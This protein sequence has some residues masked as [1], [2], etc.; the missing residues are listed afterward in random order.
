VSCTGGTAC[1]A[2]GNYATAAAL[3]LTLAEA[4]RGTTWRAQR[5]PSPGGAATAQLSGVS[6][7]RA[8]ACVA[9]GFRAESSGD[10]TRSLAEAWHGTSWRIQATPNVAAGGALSGVSCPVAGMCMAVGYYLNSSLLPVT[11][12]E[13]WDGTSWKIEATPVPHGASFS[14]LSGVSCTGT[15][16][17]TAV[18]DYSGGTLAEAWNGTT[19]KIE[20][21]PNPVGSTFSGLSG[22]SCPT[23]DACTAVG[24][25]SGG[26]LAEVW[27]GTTW[28]IQVTPNP[29]GATRIGLSA[30]SCAT[31]GSCTAVGSYTNNSGVLTTLAEARTGTSWRIEA[32][33]ASKGYQGSDLLGVS[34]TAVT[35]CVA[36]G[37]HPRSLTV[38]ALAEAWDGSAWKIESTTLP[39]R[40]I[41]SDLSGVSCP[42]AGACTA[43]G[44]YTSPSPDD[45]TL[46]ERRA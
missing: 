29:A 38:V 23:A 7:I 32:T 4:R 37:V 2:A 45:L 30:V 16:A 5:T 18:G 13:Q 46:A 17:C 43:V 24:H 6:C 12:A 25:Y 26:T 21:T 3:S 40:S 1:T 33:P 36:V 15:G 41:N 19:W 31:A 27:H 42:A 9:V 34:C 8:D 44:S 20:A 10:N 39:A 35:A 22:V 14:E 28:T 11:L